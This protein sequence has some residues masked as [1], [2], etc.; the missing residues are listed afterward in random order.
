ME[1]KAKR[2]KV[3]RGWAFRGEVVVLVFGDGGGAGVEGR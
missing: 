2:V 3:E 1:R